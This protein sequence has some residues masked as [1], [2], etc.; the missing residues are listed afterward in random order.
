MS[1]LKKYFGFYPPVFFPATGF[2]ILFL[3]SALLY[4]EVLEK[5]ASWLQEQLFTHVGWFIILSVN[6]FLVLLF[7]IALGKFGKIRIGGQ[8]AKPEFS[9]FAWCSMLFTAGMGSGTLFFSI[10]EPITH[11]S[12]PP[13]P[14]TS[15]AEAASN[16]IKFAYL[17]HGFHGWSL[18][19][20][21]G[22]SV[23]FFHFNRKGSLTMSAA[24]VPILRGRFVTFWSSLVNIIAVIATLFGVALSLGIAAEL[25]ADGLHNLF[26]IKNTLQLQLIAIG[27][28]TLGSTTSV[29]LGLK[30]GIK[31]LSNFN[32]RL[33]LLLMFVMLFLGP[34]SFILDSFVQN[35]GAYLQDFIFLSSYSEAGVE[36][37]W[38]NQWTLFYWV[39]WIAWAPFAGIF[40]AKISKGRTVKQFILGGLIAPV[41]LAFFWYGVFGGSALHLEMESIGNLSGIVEE[42]AAS[43]FFAMLSHY[44]FPWMTS[45]A[46]LLLGIIFFMTSSDSASL[47]NDYLTS[48]GNPNPSKG[49]RIFWAVTEGIVAAILLSFGGFGVINGIVTLTGFPFLM[50]MF[51]MSYSLYKGLKQEY[52][53][54]VNP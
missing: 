3:I 39:W 11:F 17:H 45:F 25:I 36:E 34:T 23:A 29:V 5:S 19:L 33:A 10:A 9:F 7:V 26:G 22:L 51:V 42:N 28:I 6:F 18:Y 31:V 37:N 4:D 2:I 12:N 20:L 13:L 54:T 46:F 32:M 35:T 16:A 49:Q 53:H 1:Y 52:Q 27:I 41:T 8:E 47:V 24:L 14:V 43:G 15:D 48:G 30:K 38:Q 44:P 50:V 40:L 21:I